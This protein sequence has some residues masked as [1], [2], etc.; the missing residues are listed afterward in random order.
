MLIDYQKLGIALNQKRVIKIEDKTT[1]ASSRS[2]AGKIGISHNTFIRIEHGMPCDLESYAK[3]C[4]FLKVS[5]DT[6]LIK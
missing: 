1:L 3:I 4:N 2:M 6:F 5:L